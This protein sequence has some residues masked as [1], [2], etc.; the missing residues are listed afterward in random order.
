MSSKV[1]NKL[2]STQMEDES[3]RIMFNWKLQLKKSMKYYTCMFPCAFALC[4]VSAMAKQVHFNASR[5][6]QFICNF[7]LNNFDFYNKSR[8]VN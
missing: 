3:L 8:K 1:H 4:L 2:H 6:V 7:S 5:A